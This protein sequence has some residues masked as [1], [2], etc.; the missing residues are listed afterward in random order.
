M[1]KLIL[2]LL[3]A[4]LV[5]PTIRFAEA[6]DLDNC[7]EKG[8]LPMNPRDCT[9]LRKMQAEDDA[10]DQASK[11]RQ[12]EATQRALQQRAERQAEDEKNR[13][14]EE[15]QSRQLHDKKAAEEIAQ[16]QKD[17]ADRNKKLSKIKADPNNLCS[18]MRMVAGQMMSMPCDPDKKEPWEIEQEKEEAAKKQKCG[19]DF[20][21]LRIGMT[22]ERVEQCYEE[23]EYVTET[24]SNGG[25]VETYRG[26]F[27]FINVK[28]G[29][30]VGYTRRIR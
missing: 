27:Y 25:T 14:L 12:Q 13:I 16:Y 5:V 7:L 28:N 24:V 17:L 9:A 18:E 1:K 19:K 3:Y 29:R 6:Y 2:V 10:Q 21:A 8:G 30:I 20:M 22:L 23:P 4:A 11:K 15:D 26:T